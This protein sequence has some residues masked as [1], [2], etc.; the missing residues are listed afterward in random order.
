MKRLQF[1]I[2]QSICFSV[3]FFFCQPEGIKYSNLRL[4]THLVSLKR[5]HWTYFCIPKTKIH[6]L[7]KGKLYPENLKGICFPKSSRQNELHMH[8][9]NIG[10]QLNRD[11]K[12]CYHP[13]TPS[14][15]I[16]H[17]MKIY[18]L[19]ISKANWSS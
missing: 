17:S 14:L 15:I 5:S 13:C 7:W 16:I 3:V 18:N 8:V 12:I 6:L 11:P 1:E 2:F 10:M 19:T 9:K 4:R